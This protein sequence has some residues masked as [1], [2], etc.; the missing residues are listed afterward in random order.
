MALSPA[1]RLMAEG[2][3]DPSVAA[4]EAAVADTAAPASPTAGVQAPALPEDSVDSGA[5]AP[6]TNA[7]EGPST[8]PK[9][10]IVVPGPAKP[11][12]APS[13]YKFSNFAL[14]FLGGALLCGVAGFLLGTSG[15]NGIDWSKARVIPAAS[16]VGGGLVGGLGSF[17]LGA[18]TPEEARPPQVEGGLPA[19]GLQA[20][21][22]F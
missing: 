1:L 5:P 19:L 13:R 4:A 18:Y 2:Q 7:T 21:L 12:E 15:P 6:A 20:S 9:D 11:V 3:A 16:A 8:L 14:G 22:R 10:K 17:W